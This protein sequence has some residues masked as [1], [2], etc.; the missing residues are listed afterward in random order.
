MLV[1]RIEPVADGSPSMAKELCVVSHAYLLKGRCV[2][3]NINHRKIYNCKWK[4]LHLWWTKNIGK[5]QM[6][7]FFVGYFYIC[8]SKKVKQNHCPSC[9]YTSVFLCQCQWEFK[10]WEMKAQVWPGCEYKLWTHPQLQHTNC[11][12]IL[13][14]NPHQHCTHLQSAAS[15]N[16]K[17]QQFNNLFH[18][19][20]VPF[21]LFVT[22]ISS[23]LAFWP[24]YKRNPLCPNPKPNWRG[25]TH[26]E[27]VA[28]QCSQNKMN[29][30]LCHINSLP[31]VSEL[32]C[33]W[34]STKLSSTP[35]IPEVELIQ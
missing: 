7:S 13:M 3:C 23:A 9:I 10:P 8:R 22:I 12:I 27:T 18:M 29:A 5:W 32:Q 15:K 34:L 21:S 4:D 25:S 20:I 30:P 35:Y 31:I 19:E 26:N 33:K 17:T 28:C 24:L 2:L 6:I 11:S 16:K 14:N 1:L